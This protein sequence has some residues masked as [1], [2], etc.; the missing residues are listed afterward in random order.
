MTAV[1]RWALVAVGCMVLV[2]IPVSVRSWPV[3]GSDL[4]AAQVLAMVDR[5]GH[6]PYSGLVESVGSLELPVSD[7]FSD[8]AAL[9][10][11][12]T[13]MRVWWRGGDDW[14]IDQ[15]RD[16]GESDLVRHG[17][18]I[19]TWNYESGRV[20]V[21]TDQPI[22]LPRASD[23][24]P[25]VLAA[26]MLSGATAAQVTR[27]ATVRVAGHT[28]IGIRLHPSDGLSSIDH[29][30]VY[31]DRGTGLPLEVQLYGRGD[32]AP[33]VT[34][35][36]VSVSAGTPSPRL[37]IA[38]A[39]AGAEVHSN[40]FGDI[41][42]GANFFAPV[43]PPRSL[44]GLAVRTGTG[45][46]AVGEYGRGPTRLIAIPLWRTATEHL[47][48][49]LRTTPGVVEAASGTSVA[50]GPLDILLTP[51]AG[52]GSSWVLAGSLTHAAMV[53]AGR[54]LDASGRTR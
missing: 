44:D 1:R 40:S 36:F 24:L 41:A 13:R 54:E 8:V 22:R 19:D 34:T 18:Q 37:T 3:D 26:S 4:S 17:R 5:S 10:G 43:R 32:S 23:L 25:P 15:L 35:S 46:K 6:Q 16:S 48:A 50:V 52:D 2:G 9:L 33:A 29:V 20:G 12:T 51:S 7:E 11:S 49:Q 45:I 47:R 14:R 31:A 38:P 53:R 21:G 39:P 27:L 30:D 28:A 42:A